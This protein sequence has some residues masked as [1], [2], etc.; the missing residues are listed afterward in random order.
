M[1]NFTL[2]RPHAMS[3]SFLG[4]KAPLI[5]HCSPQNPDE[6]KEWTETISINI[7]E[8]NKEEVEKLKDNFDLADVSV[9]F[10]LFWYEEIVKL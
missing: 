5:L 4:E 10:F 7:L 1:C 8:D 3:L 6:L 9:L 2:H